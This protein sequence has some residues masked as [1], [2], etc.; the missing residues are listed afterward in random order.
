MCSSRFGCDKAGRDASDRHMSD[1]LLKFRIVAIAVAFAGCLSA[2]KP[3][4]LDFAAIEGVPSAPPV[5][6]ATVQVIE[7]AADLPDGITVG[8]GSGRRLRDYIVFDTDMPTASNP[9]RLLGAVSAREGNRDGR[10]ALIEAARAEAGRHGGNAIY[11]VGEKLH[12]EVTAL[13]LHVSHAA[14]DKVF[15]TASALLATPPADGYAPSGD[16][17]AIDLASEMS[18]RIAAER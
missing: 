6:A 10:P 5:D 14:H 9:H 1:Q 18:F 11:L 3:I 15:P 2:R 4:T 12:Y 16:P 7:R 13:V 17:I 8:S